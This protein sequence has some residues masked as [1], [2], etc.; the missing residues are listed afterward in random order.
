MRAEET[1]KAESEK[2]RK[3]RRSRDPD[4]V[5]IFPNYISLIIIMLCIIQLSDLAFLS[6]ITPVP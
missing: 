4:V 5:G 6:P 3:D 2:H 1:F